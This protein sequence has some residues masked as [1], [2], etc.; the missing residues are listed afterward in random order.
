MGN[1]LPIMDLSPAG[2][3]LMRLQL[4]PEFFIF[5]G[6]IED[7]PMMLRWILSDLIRQTA[8]QKV[9][10]AV[11]AWGES[12]SRDQ[13]QSGS[14]RELPPCEIAVLFGTNLEAEDFASSL[15]ERSTTRCASFVEHA[16][17]LAGQAVVVIETGAG[18]RA[19]GRAA[20]DVIAMHHPDWVVSAGFAAALRPELRRGHILM[21]DQVLAAQGDPLVVGF[22]IDPQ[23]IAAMRH[24][25]VGRL[26]TVHQPVRQPNARRELGEQY[27]ALA[28]DM[29]TAAVA[30]ICGRH[31]T[32]FLS[33][34]V[35]ADQVEDRMPV[36]I[37]R[38]MG[39]ASWAAKLGAVTGALLKRPSSVKD[40]WHLQ[41]QALLASDRLAEFLRGVLP[42]L[43]GQG[44]T[45]R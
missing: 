14:G 44:G 12:S 11:S 33:V 10:D 7:L 45:A 41:Q 4:S 1:V 36:E 43:T 31:K 27:Q 16:G 3:G 8:Y 21:A 13:H 32:R 9:T 38:M 2:R 20:E 40:W 23:A 22:H 24:L 19:S 35:I 37:E 18:V 42:Q 26:V 39:K 30:E 15:E 25:H 5:Q 17:F 6:N 34:R 29:E 28:A